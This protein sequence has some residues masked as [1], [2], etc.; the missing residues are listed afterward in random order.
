MSSNTKFDLVV[1]LGGNCAAAHQLLYKNFRTAAY[2]FDWTYFTSD[3]AVYQLAKGFKEEFKN[4][5]LKENFEEL[6]VNP[7]HPDRIQYKDKYGKIIWANHFNYG[8]D[9]YNEVKEK[10]TRRFERLINSIKKAHRIIFVFS[11]SF[12][13][14]PD[15]FFVLLDTLDEL[16]PDKHIEIKVVSFNADKNYKYKN[17]NIEIFYYKR[18]MNDSDYGSTNKEWDFLD[19]INYR[20]RMV[21]RIKKELIKRFIG[22]IPIRTIRHKLQ[23]K[24]HVK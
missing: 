16:Y 9:D 24:Y 19:K 3:E 22:L 20:V 10:L 12:K 21:D 6:P 8:K 18:Q 14:E 23:R 11:V 4:Y 2:P 17:N 15:A 1:S 7:S 5:A 13:I